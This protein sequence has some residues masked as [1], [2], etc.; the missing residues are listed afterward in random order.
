MRSRLVDRRD[1]LKA[2]GAG[3]VAALSHR[4]LAGTLAADA[5][6]ATSY[7]R[8]DG[9]YGAA[10]LSEQ[11]KVLHQVTL[12]DRGHD[13]TFDPVSRR[14]VV[15][16]RQPGTFMVVFDHAGRAE[17]VT[18]AS[19]PGRHFRLARGRSRQGRP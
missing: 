10:I 7:L 12:P 1:F 4:A 8:R 11:G 15:F 6:F 14:S 18:I 2:A 13:I 9:A 19:V 16:A 17:P 3:F 5:V